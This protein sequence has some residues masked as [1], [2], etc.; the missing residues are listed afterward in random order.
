M[1]SLHQLKESTK[2][3][4]RIPEIKNEINTIEIARNEIESHILQSQESINETNYKKEKN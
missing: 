2:L 3:I 1:Q 4:L